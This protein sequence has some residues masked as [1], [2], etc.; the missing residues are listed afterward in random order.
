MEI[1]PVKT[2]VTW[3]RA[4]DLVPPESVTQ[5][6][7]VTGVT[8]PVVDI[9]FLM[10]VSLLA[11]AGAVWAL[12][13]LSIPGFF[14]MG[15]FAVV[16][17]YVGWIRYQQASAPAVSVGAGGVWLAGTDRR[18]GQ[19]IPWSNV[20]ELVFFTAVERRVRDTRVNRH[21]ALGVR[22]RTPDLLPPEERA[23]LTRI[24]QSLPKRG[25]QVMTSVAQWEAMPYR[26]IGAAGRLERSSLAKAVAGFAPSVR[27]VNGPRLSYLTPWVIGEADTPPPAVLQPFVNAGGLFPGLLSALNA[28]PRPTPQPATP[29]Q[30]QANPPGWPSSPPP[31][32][33]P[34]TYGPRGAEP[35][36]PPS[37]AIR[38]DPSL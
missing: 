37:E 23:L 17:G 33:G 25:D 21:R 31:G 22:L 11:A 24:A 34:G 36:H 32:A 20:E 8:G 10:V 15:L 4:R 29:P 13:H 28:T 1:K 14:I 26:Q 27:V 9:L 30:Q 5:G 2:Q 7:P 6:G 38:P 16:P 19:A 18:A 35:G 12:A 3:M